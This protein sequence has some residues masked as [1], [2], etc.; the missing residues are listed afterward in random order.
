MAVFAA[1]ILVATGCT[2]GGPTAAS[3]TPAAS[4]TQA[5]Q[6]GGRIIEGTFSDIRTLQPVLVADTPS[7]RITDLIY[8]RLIQADPQN[9]E[10]K[11]RMAT[12]T[13]GAGGKSYTFTLNA[14]AN[15]SDGK[16]IIAEDWATG[17]KA[18]AMSKV[19]VRKSDFSNI[20]GFT[21][22]S[23]GKAN[24]ISGIAI[25][26]ANPKKWTVTL[27]TVQ[28]D[29]IFQMSGYTLPAHVFGKYV[30]AGQADAIDKA[31]ENDNPTVF[32]GPFKFKEWRKGDQVILTRNDSY[33][34]GAPHAD[35]YV[36]KVVA[37][38]TVLAAQLKTGELNFGTI[39]PKDLADME[40]VDS[41]KINKYQN[42]GYTYIG[43]RV[44]SPTA[45]ALADKRVRQALAYGL[46]MDDVIKAVLFGEGQKQVAHHVP[47]QWA[48]PAPATLN[49]Y[50]YDTAK[51]EELIKAA[52]YTK[53]SA[54]LYA[55]DGKT[56]S[57]TIRTNS[58]NKTRE[59]LAQVAAEQYKKIGVDAKTQ[60]EAFQGLVTQLQEGHQSIEAVIIGWALG[61]SVDPYTIWHS[62]NTPDPA[63]KKT[64]FNFT[65]FKSPEV[66][67][68]IEEGRSPANG[69]CSIAT[70][71]GH[72]AT[73]NKI[74]NEEQPYNF[75]FANNT[76]AVTAKN[77]ENFK[78]GPFSA[79]YNIHEWWFKK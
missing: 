3:P 42:L 45:T 8:D 51:A 1:S 15:W 5:P 54:G 72:Y 41:V 63:T 50:P 11:P 56:I 53:N 49:A 36:Y 57:F 29:G 34:Q 37:D 69:D 21:E 74:L 52:G 2:T 55:K 28:C 12:F 10:P 66:D 22:F 44:N 9:G 39:E 67:K 16:P 26:P 4:A 73:M 43:W 14:N 25:D 46:N 18:V 13:A 47:V 6:K 20:E 75:G 76:L 71:K 40:R 60:F 33:W 48:Y 38:A 68:A 32:S 17:V 70:R 64:G 27:K 30:A 35:E 65:F 58:G 61:N 31:P 79:V 23:E 78:P 7:G 59:T 62:S 77:L 24:N 19:T